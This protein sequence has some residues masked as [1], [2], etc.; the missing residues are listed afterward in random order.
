ME[1][2]TGFD[3]ESFYFQNDIPASIRAETAKASEQ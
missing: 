3:D 1:R 2:L